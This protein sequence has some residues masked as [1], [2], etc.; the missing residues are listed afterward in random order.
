MS[1]DGIVRGKRGR[2]L[3]LL[4]LL[5]LRAGRSRD[6][7][8]GEEDALRLLLCFFML[9]VVC[10]EHP[11]N[12]I[13]NRSVVIVIGFL[14]FGSGTNPTFGGLHRVYIKYYIIY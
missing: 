8:G 2:L 12:D 14:I 4:L 11:T 7:G 13:Y 5:L 1:V 3:L 10:F 9:D 6:D